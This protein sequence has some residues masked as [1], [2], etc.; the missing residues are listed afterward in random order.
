MKLKIDRVARK[1]GYT[2]GKMYIDGVYLCDT[3]EDADRGLRQDMPLDE[4]RRRKVS[5]ATAIPAGTY[6]VRMDVVSPKYSQ[7]EAYRSIGGRLPR[8]ENVP[9]YEGVLIHIGNYPEDTEG[10]I[11]VGRNKQVGAVIDST[12]TFW[13]LHAK[14]AAAAGDDDEITLEIC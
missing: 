6:T 10:C 13:E 14:L 1:P 3:L 9:G 8:L 4:L 11:L 12:K 2:I 7:R 5:G